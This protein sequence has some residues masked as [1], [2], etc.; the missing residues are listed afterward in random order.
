MSKYQIQA[1]YQHIL[2]KDVHTQDLRQQ[3][4]E[5]AFNCYKLRKGSQENL[6]SQ[7]QAKFTKHQELRIA[8]EN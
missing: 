8:G 2:L 4:H 1:R 7:I 3:K 5:H 6:K